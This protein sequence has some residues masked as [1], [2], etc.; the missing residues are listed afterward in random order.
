MAAPGYAPGGG[1]VPGAGVSTSG[2]GGDSAGRYAGRTAGSPAASGRS[3]EV[4]GAVAAVPA[5]AIPVGAEPGG[6]RLH[7]DVILR[8]RNPAALSRFV[9]AVSTPG[10]PAYH[11]FLPPGR[12][13]GEFGASRGAVRVVKGALE[14]S[15]MAVSGVTSNRL[16]IKVDARAAAVQSV[17]HTHLERYRLPGGREVFANTVAPR[18]PAA[19]ASFVTDVAG[20][21]DLTQEQPQSRTMPPALPASGGGG[22]ERGM[23]ARLL[24]R[25]SPVS[26]PMSTGAGQAALPGAGP[27]FTPRLSGR[28]APADFAG[29]SGTR[30][31]GR[32]SA[33]ASSVGSHAAGPQPCSSASAVASQRGAYTANEL[34]SAYGFTSAYGAGR[35][36]AGET[37]ALYE[38][39]TFA[40]GDISA[41]QSCYGTSARVNTIKIDGGGTAGPG[42]ASE[43]TLDIEDVIGLVPQATVDVYEAPETGTGWIDD[44]NR[45]ATDDTAQVVSTSWGECEPVN[46]KLAA[47]S[48]EEVFEQMAA[49]GQSVFSAAGDSGSE[50][51]F[52]MPAE[53]SGV[54]CGP[55]ASTCYAAGW[56][57]TGAGAVVPVTGGSPGTSRSV[58]AAGLGLWAIS[59]SGQSTCL[60]VGPT[61]DAQGNPNGGLTVPVNGGVPGAAEGV[62]GASGGLYGVACVSVSVC[63]AVGATSSGEGVMVPV[64]NGVPGSLLADSQ[65]T[66][67]FAGIACATSTTCYAVGAESSGNGIVVPITVGGPQVAALPA[68]SRRRLAGAGESRRAE[69]VGQVAPKSP[70]VITIGAVEPL[71]GGGG[72]AISGLYGVTCPS[73]SWCVVAGSLSGLGDVAVISNGSLGQAEPVPASAGGLYGVSCTGTSECYAVGGTAYTALVATLNSGVPGAARDALAPGLAVDDPASD[74]YVT[75][76]GGTDL[77][78]VGPPPAESVWNETASEEGAG[79]GGISTFWPMPSWQQESGVPG[80]VGSQSSGKPCGTSGYCREVPDVSAS[81][82]G[83]KDC[84]G[85]CRIS[86][87]ARA[88]RTNRWFLRNQPEPSG[89]SLRPSPRRSRYRRPSRAY[90]RQR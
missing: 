23:E 80:V 49:Q 76:V 78:A 47:L 24:R 75:G 89:Q 64:R 56:D 65:V 77:Q 45:I 46:G 21:D 87:T 30:S 34:A 57:S 26:L 7:L 40:T 44:W 28:G 60:A 3:L 53:F 83:V 38:L 9:A 43:V 20:L 88:A 51:C 14:L 66:G 85:A 29:L 82:R 50:D 11:H 16:T 15:G 39:G 41:Y 18:L 79:G 17:L 90:R 37:V 5:G 36:G 25:A 19:A 6:A 8:S 70:M 4:V 42:P 27:R 32:G 84:P 13:G 74:P 33:L 35:L 81:A 10:S 48:E 59:C 61:A 12:F 73:T 71:A 22:I 54:S 72:A 69:E 67:G 55:G 58:P 52:Q 63:L 2:A 68:P 86:C 31:S 62:P 1:V